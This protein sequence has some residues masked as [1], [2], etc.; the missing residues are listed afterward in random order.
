MDR[1]TA[2]KHVYMASRKFFEGEPVPPSW[3]D[4]ED[5][6]LAED[7]APAQIIYHYTSQAGFE[8]I[9]DSAEGLCATH[10]D[11]LN[12]RGE[13]QY[14][15]RIVGAAIEDLKPEIGSEAVGILDERLGRLRAEDSF[16]ACFS[17]RHDSLSQWRSYADET[18]GYCIGYR[19]ESTQSMGYHRTYRF[20]AFG[21][22]LYG[23]DTVRERVKGRLRRKIDRINR[24]VAAEP[25]WASERGRFL[26]SELAMVAWR[27]AHLAKHEHFREEQE[28]R[29]MIGPLPVEIQ[30]RK[31]GESEIPYVMTGPLEI[32]EVWIGGGRTETQAEAER[33]TKD[34]LATKKIQAPVTYWATPYLAQSG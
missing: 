17:K 29:C 33:S 30:Y 34:L 20:R 11:H 24:L 14:G 26:A 27:Q 3:L 1:A 5:P 28:Y 10:K 13:I 22:C 6:D 25:K 23:D 31:R 16:V 19:P 4:L 32:K 21:E 12:D 18:K 8:G 15:Y 2:K 9:V 7:M